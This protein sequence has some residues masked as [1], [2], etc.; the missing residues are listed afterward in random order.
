MTTKVLIFV[1]GVAVGLAIAKLYARSQWSGAIHD[2]LAK[3][4]LGGGPIEETV[5]R[6]ILPTVS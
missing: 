4:G 3:L 6:V 1:G 5:D 2:G